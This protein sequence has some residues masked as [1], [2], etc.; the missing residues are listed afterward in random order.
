MVI[1]KLFIEPWNRD[2]KST[3]EFFSFRMVNC[4]EYFIIFFLSHVI[5]LSKR[6]L[7]YSKL[8]CCLNA[9]NLLIRMKMAF[10]CIKIKNSFPF[11]DVGCTHME[12]KSSEKKHC[13]HSRINNKEFFSTIICHSCTTWLFTTCIFYICRLSALV[14]VRT[15]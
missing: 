4:F 13:H 2:T 12:K 3:N 15:S 11:W 1:I 9:L 14:H 6:H 10:S 8:K 7:R 5:N